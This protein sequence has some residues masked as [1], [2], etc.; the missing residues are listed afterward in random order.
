MRTTARPAQAPK[1]RTRR[2]WTVLAVVIVGILLV[3]HHF[4]FRPGKELAGTASAP[5]GQSTITS[6]MQNAEPAAWDTSNDR[7]I[8]NRRG[9]GGLWNAY[10]ILPDGRGQ[11]CL[12]CRRPFFPGV[13]TATNRGAS[14]VSPNGR[15][16]LLVVEKGVHPGTIGETAAQPGKGVYNDIWLATIDGAHV[17]RLTDLPTSETD[18]VIWPRFDRTGSQIVWSQMYDAGGASHP[19]GEWALKTARL[20][21]SG[22]TPRLADI[23]TYEPQ[24]GRFFEPYGFSPSNQRIIFASDI[25][26][27][28]GF[29]SPSA[30]NSQIWTIDAA[31]LDDLQRVTPAFHLHGMF[32]DYNEFAFYLPGDSDRLLIARTFAATAHGMDYWT[33]N[34]NGT[35]PRRITFMNQP[36]TRQYLGYS[37]GL[38]VAFD[39]R[40]PRRLVAGVSH[41]LG[42]QHVQA[43]FMTIG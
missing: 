11:L 36:G 16:V 25:H 20:G 9:P 17:W 28:G 8:L 39:P 37:V 22:G 13:V 27:T 43:V 41:D 26:V 33:I 21:W 30:F 6:W 3:L 15:Y 14:D 12:T 5:Q 29:L 35:D 24:A 2:R 42:T 31:H 23:R 4:R 19:L 38:G 32:S 40:D 1:A 7:I 10:T 34:V 18:G